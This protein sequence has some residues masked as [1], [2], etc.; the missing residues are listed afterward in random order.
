MLSV[1]LSGVRAF[2]HLVCGI[3]F[4]LLASA[5]CRTTRT[6]PPNSEQI[7]GCWV[8]FASDPTYFFL[9][10]IGPGGKGICSRQFLSNP[11]DL[12]DIEQWTLDRWHLA[13]TVR[14]VKEGVWP[15]RITGE[16]RGSA[17]IL[18]VADF[19]SEDTWKSTVRAVRLETWDARVKDA[20]AAASGNK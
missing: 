2:A 4:C 1:N 7:Q 10:D 13:I 20:L 16:I 5:G 18:A 8:G 3:T 15:M 14:A 19:T 12:F 17:L 11:P 9:L 6:F